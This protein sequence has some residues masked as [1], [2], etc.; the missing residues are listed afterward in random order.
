MHKI[1]FMRAFVL[2]LLLAAG[3]CSA[4]ADTA[5]WLR[6]FPITDYMVTLND[7]TIVVQVEMPEDLKFQEKQLGLIYCMYRTSVDDAVQKGYGRC[8][9]IKGVFHYFAISHNE[10]KLPLTKGDLV[11]AFMPQTNIYYDRIA[12]V[13]GH[14]IRL[15]DVYAKPYYDR[16]NIFLKWTEA[17]EKALVD[18]MA[19]CKAEDVMKFVD[20]IIAR[21]RAYAGKEWK[22]SEIFATWV[23]NGAPG[24]K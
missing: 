10:S 13:A 9:L 11:F 12:R 18:S 6:G 15:Q 3:Q 7:T 22:V 24:S 23:N 2:I 16:Y 19:E 20:Y 4:Q 14:F 17:E 21:P 1:I 8:Q 5:K